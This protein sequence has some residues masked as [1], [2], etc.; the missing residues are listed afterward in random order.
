[1]DPNTALRNLRRAIAR[2]RDIQN[3]EVGPRGFDRDAYQ[4]EL[5]DCVVDLCDAAESLD[6]WLRKGGFPPDLW[7]QS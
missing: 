7:R 6:G 1:M 2:V 5:A 3:S 4:A